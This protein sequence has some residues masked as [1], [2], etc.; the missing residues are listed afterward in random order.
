MAEKEKDILK[1]KVNNL[2]IYIEENTGIINTVLNK[3]QL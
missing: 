2:K 3:D 1:S